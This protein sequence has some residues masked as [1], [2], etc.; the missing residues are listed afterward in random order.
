MHEFVDFLFCD[1]KRF[2][3]NRL[4]LS[5]PVIALVVAMLLW[6]SS[7]IAL[8]YAFAFYHP[9]QVIFLRMASASVCFLLVLPKLLKVNY[10]KGDWKLMLL[11]SACEP[12]LYFVLEAEALQ[13][14]SASQAGMI[15]AM[16]PLMVAVVAYLFIGE[17]INRQTLIGFVL[18][19]VGAIWLSLSG[20]QSQHAP[21]PL[22]GNALELT[23]MVC[24]AFYSVALKHLSAR[25]SAVFLTAL[26]AFVGALFFLPL[27][28]QTEIPAQL[29]MHGMA[30]ILYLGVCVTLGAYLAYNYAITRLPVSQAAAYINLIPVFT[31]LFA[32]LLL[33]DVLN[34][35]QLLASG[36]IML[37]LIY[38]QWRSKPLATEPLQPVTESS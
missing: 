38:S 29:N 33:D 8:K 16:A 14:T 34:S 37:G 21:N 19:I 4:N 12:C 10:Q 32:Y 30:A 1:L 5:A 28:M 23:A 27:A 18:A 22:L 6:G 17:R 9:M 35:E 31:L 15:V 13:H 26:Q 7:F 3:V 36:L 24:A 25:Y 11:M 2:V 20:E